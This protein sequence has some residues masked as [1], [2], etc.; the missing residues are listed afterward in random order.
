MTR[1]YF[2]LLI[3]CSV[4]CCFTAALSS[5]KSD[6]GT[7][8]SQQPDDAELEAKYERMDVERLAVMELLRNLADVTFDAEYEG[9]IDFE[10][11]SYEPTI[12]PVRDEANPLERSIRVASAAEE[13]SGLCPV[14]PEEYRLFRGAFLLLSCRFQSAAG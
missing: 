2:R 12:G 13:K 7:D 1:K 5:C 3:F 9:D 6:D 11:K 8:D 4:C 10:G 14:L